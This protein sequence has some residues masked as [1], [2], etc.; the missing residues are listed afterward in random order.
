MT[1]VLE[2]VMVAPNI[3]IS[4]VNASAATGD[5]VS[6]KNYRK[7]NVM[8][9]FAAGTATTGDLTVTL[10]QTTDVSNSLSDAK[11]LAV[12]QTGRIY[13]KQAATA[14]TSVTGWTAETQT[15]AATYTSTTSG[16]QVGLWAFEVRADDLDVDNG[17][18]CIRA[19][20][21][22]TTSSKYVSSWYV[23]SDPVY[24]GAPD[25]M[26]DPLVD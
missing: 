7:C 1:K 12:L 10:Q 18:D 23:L 3:L 8:V 9:Y 5:I 26:S 13:T 20:I 4:D 6:L 17:F 11:N 25:L 21:G 22:A 2:D 19:N 15:A 14:L 24:P 16:E